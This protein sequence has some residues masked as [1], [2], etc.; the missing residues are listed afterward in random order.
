[1]RSCCVMRTAPF[2]REIPTWWK[3]ERKRS[4]SWFFPFLLKATNSSLRAQSSGL[5]HFSMAPLFKSPPWGIHF[6]IHFGEETVI[7][8]ISF[9]NSRSPLGVS[10]NTHFC[11]TLNSRSHLPLNKN[12]SPSLFLTTK[13]HLNS[14]TLNGSRSVLTSQS[15]SLF[16]SQ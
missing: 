9:V 10:K 16:A 12:L 7:T 6:S 3:P 4:L 15:H 1:M 11:D 5:S 8:A 2:L 14:H 13:C